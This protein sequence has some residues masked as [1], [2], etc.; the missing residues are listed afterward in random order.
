LLLSVEQIWPTMP[1][2]YSIDVCYG[3]II[4]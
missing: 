3:L 4:W 1:Y 2:W